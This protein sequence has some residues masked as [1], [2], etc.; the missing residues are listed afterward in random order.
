MTETLTVLRGAWEDSVGGGAK[1][2]SELDAKMMQVEDAILRLK[3]W[4]AEP[5]RERKWK[6]SVSKEYTD[7]SLGKVS[8]GFHARRSELDTLVRREKAIAKEKEKNP[9]AALPKTITTSVPQ[10][11]ATAPHTADQAAGTANAPAT[12]VGRRASST[13]SHWTSAPATSSNLRM[14]ADVVMTDA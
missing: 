3:S 8:S 5:E 14:N 10:T 12:G 7:L 6:A 4:M 1:D 13:P 11:A 9:L 2:E